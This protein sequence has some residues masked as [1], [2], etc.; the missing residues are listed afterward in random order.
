MEQV[1]SSLRFAVVIDLVKRLRAKGSWCGET[2]IQK[3]IFILQDISKSNF[4]YKFIMYKHGPYSFD[5]NNE[6]VAM[7]ASNLI[8]YKFPREG[9]GP[10][11]VTSDFADRLFDLHHEDV[12]K[13]QRYS[14]LVANWFGAQDVKYLERVATA[15]FVTTKHSREPVAS[16]AKRVNSLKPHV[17]LQSAEEAVQIVDK[18]RNEIKQRIAA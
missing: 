17:D 18:M 3:A 14:Q 16:R 4:G 5:L 15:Y 10:S 2:H 6:L 8:S 11:I 13:L 7:K 12:K 9:Y 1:S